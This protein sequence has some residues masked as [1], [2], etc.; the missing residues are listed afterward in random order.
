MQLDIDN[1]RALFSFGHRRSIIV[2]ERSHS[3]NTGGAGRHLACMYLDAEATRNAV[4][5]TVKSGDIA[6]AVSAPD[7][8][9]I[10]V[11]SC[12]CHRRRR[13]VATLPE[14]NIADNA[15]SSYCYAR[16]P[17]L[18]PSALLTHLRPAAQI[19]HRPSWC[20]RYARQNRPTRGSAAQRIRN[21]ADTLR[22]CRHRPPGE[23]RRRHQR[24]DPLCRHLKSPREELHFRDILLHRHAARAALSA[25]PL[26]CMV[27]TTQSGSERQV[28]DAPSP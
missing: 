6:C 12:V 24:L 21:D 27:D 5:N 11:Q 13:C 26:S 17:P 9:A 8:R 10:N 22:L 25:S 1:L 20:T 18:S 2:A 15:L 14:G 23:Q 28:G 7:P 19:R 16:A 3:V 4:E